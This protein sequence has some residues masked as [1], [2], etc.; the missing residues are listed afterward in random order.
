MMNETVHNN[1]VSNKP[2]SPII[3]VHNRRWVILIIYM[4]YTAISCFQW[5]EY[6]IITNLVVDY[7]GVSASAVDWTAMC[8]MVAWP[9]F[10]FP[11]SYM[12]ERVGLRA[13]A[14]IGAFLTAIG[15][16]IKLFAYGRDLFYVVL[17]GQTVVAISQVFILNL[18]P[19][20]A[21]TWFKPSEV[22]TVCSL[23]VFGM[24]LGIAL[25]FLLPPVIVKN[26]ENVDD[27]G[28][29]INVMCWGTAIAIAPVALT[30]LFYFPEEPPYP[31]SQAQL[32]GRENKEVVNFKVFAESLKVLFKNKAFLI[33]AFS[34]GLNLAIYSAIGTLLNQFILNYFEEAQE[35][36]G[37]MGLVMI[38]VGMLGSILVGVVLDKTHRYKEAAIF[39]F[40]MSAISMG[41]FLFALEMRSKWMIYV[42]IGVFGFFLNAYLP[43]GIEFAT[44]ITFPSPESTVAG[45]L[46]A[47][48]QVFGVVFTIALAEINTNYGT[49]YSVLGQILILI[50][51]TITT[52]FTPN[53]LNRQKAF[54]K[55]RILFEKVPDIES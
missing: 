51:G 17:I 45:L 21:V 48:S 43:A 41:G 4:I 54:L 3:K 15:A 20:I 27:I 13:A 12:I 14:L 53:T 34:Y 32:E 16:A 7:Y 55:D 30:V 10:V 47:I 2:V 36:A 35:D 42:T 49:F 46:F 18:P 8:F 52:C 1:L 37:R 26:H 31:P 11:A 38:L 39:V 29:D 40:L 23:G 6:S 44:E 5:T 33:H 50:V 19:K 24:A 28:A 22:S 25:G 9:V